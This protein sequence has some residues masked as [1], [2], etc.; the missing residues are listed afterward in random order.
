VLE[1]LAWPFPACR[2]RLPL[3]SP[4]GLLPAG[5]P[6]GQRRRARARGQRN[7]RGDRGL[8]QPCGLLLDSDGIQ[9]ELQ[10]Q[11]ACAGQVGLCLLQP[12]RIARF[13][14]TDSPTW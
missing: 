11:L 13:A 3:G 9:A 12:G 8:L 14:G 6:P 4:A 7:A 10:R 5:I 2:S 1:L